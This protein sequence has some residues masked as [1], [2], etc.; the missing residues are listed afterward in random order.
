MGINPFF[1]KVR[2]YF[3]AVGAE[4]YGGCSVKCKL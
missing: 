2:D 3:N 1:G 4:E